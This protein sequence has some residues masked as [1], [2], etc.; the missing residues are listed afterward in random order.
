MY[1]HM[2]TAFGD[3][4]KSVRGLDVEDL[5][6]WFMS[7]ASVAGSVRSSNWVHY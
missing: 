6:A 2:I 7:V 1:A 4:S 5:G 3:R